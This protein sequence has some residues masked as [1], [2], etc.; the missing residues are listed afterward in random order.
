M[1]HDLEYASNSRLRKIIVCGPHL[2]SLMMA[3]S[4]TELSK[5]NDMLGL[6]FDI[7]FKQAVRSDEEMILRWSVIETQKKASS[8]LV[9]TKITIHV[10]EILCAVAHTLDLVY[11]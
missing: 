4:G 7:E 8:T 1:H 11:D 2:S 5:E 6:K 3:M 9:K 10:N